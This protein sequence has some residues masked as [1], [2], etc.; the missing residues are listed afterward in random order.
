MSKP[1]RRIDA[2]PSDWFSD[3]CFKAPIAAPIFIG[4]WVIK[5]IDESPVAPN[6]AA[7]TLAQGAIPSGA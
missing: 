2:V 6:V 1:K 5:Y 4:E 7:A 3:R